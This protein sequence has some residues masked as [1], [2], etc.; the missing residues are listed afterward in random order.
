[1][2]DVLIK[3]SKAREIRNIIDKYDRA[4]KQSINYG[5]STMIYI[6]G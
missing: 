1:M 3:K 6:G 2:D 4:S 5:K